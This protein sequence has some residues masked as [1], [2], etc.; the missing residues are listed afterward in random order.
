MKET[1][2]V[3]TRRTLT[4]WL[5]PPEAGILYV[6]LLAFSLLAYTGFRLAF[7]LGYRSSFAGIETWRVIAGF[8]RG[9]RF[10]LS[11][12]AATLGP[13]FLLLHLLPPAWRQGRIERIVLS[14]PLPLVW[15]SFFIFFIDLNYY[16]ESGRRLS[17]EIFALSHDP[18]PALGLIM[19]YPG[20]LIL[21]IS[22][23]ALFSWAWMRLAGAAQ[24]LTVPSRG[25]LHEGAFIALFIVLSIIA[26]RGGLQVKPLRPSYAFADDT[27]ALGHLALNPVFTVAHT[28]YQGESPKPGYYSEQEALAVVR[29]ILHEPAEKFPDPRYPM[30]H[31]SG[32]NRRSPFRTNVVI[33]LMESWAGKFIGALGA[34]DSLTPNFDRLARDGVLFTNF[35]ANG[36]RSIEGMACLCCA[37][38]TFRDTLLIGGSLEQNS[39]QCLGRIFKAAGY[40]TLFIHGA[41]TGSFGFDA[42]SRRAGFDRYIGMEDFSLTRNEYDPVWGVYDD[43][44]LM[45]AN[46]EFRRARKPFLALWFSL[47]SHSPYNLPSGWVRKYPSSL[48]DR[49]LWNTILYSD[50]SLGKFFEAARKEKYFAHTIFVILADHSSGTIFANMRERFRIPC[51]MYAPGRLAPRRVDDVG[52]QVDILP[53]LMDVAGISAP[54]HAFGRSL[55]VPPPSFGVAFLDNVTVHG[56]IRDNLFLLSD[57]QKPLALYDYRS[58]PL[59]KHDLLAV[60]QSDARDMVRELLSFVQVSKNLILDNRLFPP[61]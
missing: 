6:F 33:L 17:Y 48:P 59:E 19:Y 35:Y 29:R 46:E 15:L 16:A 36:Q 32:A 44:A 1:T 20:S 2:P 31:I 41:R 40:T 13:F 3:R 39:L 8:L 26:G 21:W 45:R 47:S 5:I 12:L 49:E 14:L 27:L 30:M 18:R 9:I 55:L 38:P 52:S 25:I 61:R 54:T 22:S 11:T 43:V 10:D 24:R 53:T 7:L 4:T 34:K 51:L 37:L 28:V 56:W 23:C 50:D 42:F 57:Q 60:R 58:D